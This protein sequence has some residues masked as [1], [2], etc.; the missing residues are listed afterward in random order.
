LSGKIGDLEGTCPA[1][2]FT[3]QKTLV[4]V[5]G[6]TRYTKGSCKD[7]RNGKEVDLAGEVQS[8]GSVTATSIEVKK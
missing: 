4:R 5:T 6:S 7:L 3:V 1:M 8:D 2:R